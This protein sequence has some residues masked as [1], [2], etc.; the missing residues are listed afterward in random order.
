MGAIDA[1]GTAGGQPMQ[2]PRILPPMHMAAGHKRK[3]RDDFFSPECARTERLNRLLRV[4][5][6]FK[7]G[8]GFRH[9]EGGQA[10]AV[11]TA[12]PQRTFTFR[13]APS[14]NQQLSTEQI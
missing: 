4:P 13:R 7:N 14:S 1:T 9:L 11:R 6:A 2:R 8:S 3:R 10:F 5:D 12:R